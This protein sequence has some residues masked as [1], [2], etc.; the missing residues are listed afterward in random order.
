MIE[1][2]VDE[3][4]LF[5]SKAGQ[6]YLTVQQ[7]THFIK[8]VDDTRI[9]EPDYLKN[10]AANGLSHVD[11]KNISDISFNLFGGPGYNSYKL[12]SNLTHKTNSDQSRL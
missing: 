9:H 12:D 10:F 5:Q 2:F 6:V 3:F 11:S 1:N 4:T 7:A 8:A